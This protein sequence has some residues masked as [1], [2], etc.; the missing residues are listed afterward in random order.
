MNM[1]DASERPLPPEIDWRRAPSPSARL[2]LEE[3]LEAM[4]ESRKEVDQ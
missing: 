1:T 2:T 4:S 3:K